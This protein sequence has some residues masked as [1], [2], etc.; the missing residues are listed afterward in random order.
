[1]PLLVAIIASLPIRPSLTR[2]AMRRRAS[3]FVVIVIE[4]KVF[5]RIMIS[6]KP[7]AA[8]LTVGSVIV[9]Q[10]L[11]PRPLFPH[12]V[13]W[14]ELFPYFDGLKLVTSSEKARGK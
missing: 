8:M 9:V 7:T 3:M 5:S 4:G 14:H 1:M 2:R 10:L 11:H 12:F 13:L 6:S